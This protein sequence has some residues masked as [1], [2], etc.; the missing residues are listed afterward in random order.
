[1]TGINV[2]APGRAQSCPMP[3]PTPRQKVVIVE[4]DASL[5]E[6]LAF[7]MRVARYE[8]TA[9]RTG[10]RALAE[11][12]DCDCLVI[13]LK[14]PDIDGLTLIDQLRAR[15]IRAPAILITTN[16]DSHCRSRAALAD[17]TIV[18]KPLLD[19]RLGRH[20]AA[21]VAGAG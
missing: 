7:S 19:G 15:G 3:V 12:G 1:L 4:D 11:C 16:P 2:V 20:I 9:C 13:D 10:A 6:A 21:A 5:L 18:E 8:V 17:V 14:L